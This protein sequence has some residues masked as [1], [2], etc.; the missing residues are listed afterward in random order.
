MTL[1]LQANISDSSAPLIFILF[2]GSLFL[3]VYPGTSRRFDKFPFL[4][5]HYLHGDQTRLNDALSKQ[6]ALSRFDVLVLALVT[7][8]WAFWDQSKSCTPN[9]PLG[10]PGFLSLSR[11]DCGG[12][13]CGHIQFIIYGRVPAS[14]CTFQSLDPK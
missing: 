11:L 8:A 7:A 14:V 6:R 4:K 5:H 10:R 13:I 12:V 1:F 3:T 9:Y 2:K